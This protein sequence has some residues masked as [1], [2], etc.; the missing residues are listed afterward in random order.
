MK[1][2]LIVGL[3]SFLGGIFRYLLSF[4]VQAKVN[5]AF[6]FGTLVVN[7][8]GC[9]AIGIIFAL[10]ERHI[11]S[12]DWKLFLATGIC[13]GFTTFSAFSSETFS[14]LRSAQYGHVAIYIIASVLL[15]LLFTF[16][17]YLIP[18]IFV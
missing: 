15:G 18:R 2:I 10:S 9:F 4:F 6:P 7:L 5:V 11:L 13:G 8:L 12:H 17:G 3:G 1:L 16:L 14:M